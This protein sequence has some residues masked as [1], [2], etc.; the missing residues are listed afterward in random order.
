L[1]RRAGWKVQRQ[2]QA[3]GAD[4][5]IDSGDRKYVVELK[6]SSEGRRDRLIPLLSQAILQVQAARRR[7]SKFAVSV[8]VVGAN[9]IPDSV[10]EQLKEFARQHAPDVAVGII[11]SEGFRDFQGFGL[12]RFSE[13]RSVPPSVGSFPQTSLPVHLLSDLNQL[14]LK[15]LLAPR[16]PESP[17]NWPAPQASRL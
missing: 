16:I 10:A 14:M 13:K 1:F 6:R 7:L 4:L 3:Q 12:E 5:I 9:R 8:A 15:V 2:P 17:R 11:D